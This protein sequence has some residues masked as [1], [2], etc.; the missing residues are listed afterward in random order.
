MQ[1][2]LSGGAR[3]RLSHLRSF[4]A[5]SLYLVETTSLGADRS[6]AVEVETDP[7]GW[8]LDVHLVR[9]DEPLRDAERLQG[10]VREAILA[11]ELHRTAAN[12]TLRGAGPDEAER[13]RQLLAGERR[14]T[15]RR[16]EQLPPLEAPA[17]RVDDPRR[18]AEPRRDRPVEGVSRAGEVRV[19]ASRTD[20]VV[21]VWVD[22]A[23]LATAPEALVR[24]ALVEAFADAYE[25]GE[26]S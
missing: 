1:E 15:P 20:G 11:A 9:L 7:T 8:V 14:I 21:G 25:K 17:G 2:T 24:F 3:A 26:V 16:R 18:V 10:A 19:A 6:G 23:W 4:L 13:G 22:P 5:P 12:A